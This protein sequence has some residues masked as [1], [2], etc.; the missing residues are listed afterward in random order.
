[1]SDYIAPRLT[2]VGNV[3]RSSHKCGA[4]GRAVSSARWLDSGLLVHLERVARGGNLE[5]VP[6][7]FAGAGLP[8]VKKSARDTG[9]LEHACGGSF[10]GRAPQRKSRP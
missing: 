8:H 3:F 2:Y 5:L 1:M 7:L 9:L 6:E 10:V 4:C